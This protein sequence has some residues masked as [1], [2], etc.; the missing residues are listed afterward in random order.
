MGGVERFKQVS[1]RKLESKDQKISFTNLLE[2]KMKSSAG[3]FYFHDLL[4]WTDES[5]LNIRDNL[6]FLPNFINEHEEQLLID[7]VQR[8]LKT[9]R[10]ENTHW[11]DAIVNYREIEKSTWEDENAKIIEK[12]RRTAFT[13]DADHQ[14][15]VHVLD[16]EKTG[17]IKPHVD[18]IRYCGDVVAGL[19]LLS[20][21]VMRFRSVENNNQIVDLLVERRGLYIMRGFARYEFTHEILKNGESLFA[22]RPVL[23]DRRISIICRTYP[24]PT[25]KC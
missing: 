13:A 15:R 4:Q 5:Q 2:Q 25:V 21:A 11:D 8:R 12:I 1:N 14:D 17:W 16:L 9:M 6:L 20:D 18:S 19:C 22:G 7:E 3:Y 10:Y 23:R 24:S